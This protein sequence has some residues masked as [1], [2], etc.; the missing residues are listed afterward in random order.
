MRALEQVDAPYLSASGPGFEANKKGP[1]SEVTGGEVEVPTLEET[2]WWSSSNN[3]Q[4]T[5]LIVGSKS[6][7]R[8]FTRRGT[9]YNASGGGI[10][11]SGTLIRADGRGGGRVMGVAG[12]EGWYEG[13]NWFADFPRTI[14]FNETYSLN[15]GRT[16]RRLFN[17]P[18]FAATIDGFLAPS[19][20]QVASL[21]QRFLDADGQYVAVAVAIEQSAGGWPRCHPATLIAARSPSGSW[22]TATIPMPVDAGD[23]PA[24]TAVPD[25]AVHGLTRFSTIYA[26]N[27]LRPAKLR[28]SDDLGQSWSAGVDITPFWGGI[29]FWMNTLGRDLHP[30]PP[31]GETLPQQSQPLSPDGVPRNEQWWKEQAANGYPTADDQR[32]GYYLWLPDPLVAV[33]GGTDLGIEAASNRLVV[34]HTQRAYSDPSVES[35]PPRSTIAVFDV[36]SGMVRRS[37]FVNYY[38]LGM[39]MLGHGAWAFW[40][41]NTG[42]SYVKLT[43]D[44]GQTY[45]DMIVPVDL[46]SLFVIAPY[47]PIPGAAYLIGATFDYNGGVYIATTDDVYSGYWV[48]RAKLGTPEMLGRPLGPNDF[49]AAVNIGTRANPGPIDPCYP[50]TRDYRY[51]VPAWWNE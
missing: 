36:T 20:S 38:P 47:S 46:R 17:I 3:S 9:R 45:S 11:G 35:P 33:T 14:I 42:G 25:L 13:G 10:A 19:A 29:D 5:V 12:S 31:D 21:P 30:M 16:T 2:N 49:T 15:G 24:D 43:T 6:Y 41:Q 22:A 1:F 34:V 48:L 51:A 26:D 32:W 39:F 8:T 50:W 18:T 37:E 7:K 27:I 28:V 4:P 23:P 44:F 40:I